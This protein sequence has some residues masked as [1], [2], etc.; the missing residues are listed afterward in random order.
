MIQTI[1]V[2]QLMRTNSL[3]LARDSTLTGQTFPANKRSVKANEEPSIPSFILSG[4]L[5]FYSK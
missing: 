1:G 5:S 3:F 4:A 2:T